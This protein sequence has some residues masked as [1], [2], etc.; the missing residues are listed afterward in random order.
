MWHQVHKVPQKTGD[1]V[2]DTKFTGVIHDTSLDASNYFIHREFL[3]KKIFFC[4]Q[5]N[6][7]LFDNI[8]MNFSNSGTV[9]ESLEDSF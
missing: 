5:E 6:L 3:Y 8:Y 2:R 7:D 1:V 4:N 9:K